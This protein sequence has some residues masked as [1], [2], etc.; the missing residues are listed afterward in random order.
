V[1]SVFA[2]QVFLAGAVVIVALRLA[3]ALI[4]GRIKV[5]GIVRERNISA[6]YWGAVR[7]EIYWFAG[8]LI[9]TGAFW[10]FL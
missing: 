1:K 7:I 4:T 2:L 8:L 10:A 3:L 5:R 9:V 6:S